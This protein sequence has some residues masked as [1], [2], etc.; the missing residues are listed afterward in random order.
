MSSTDDTFYVCD[1]SFGHGIVC[2]SFFDSLNRGR[3]GRDD[4]V[5]GLTTTY[6]ISA[7]YH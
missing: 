5:D 7:Y 1:F 2:P 6:V 3:R 4:M